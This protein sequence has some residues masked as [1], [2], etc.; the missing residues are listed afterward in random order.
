MNRIW[1]CAPRDDLPLHLETDG[2]DTG[3]GAVFF[4]IVD[5]KRHVIKMCS[6]KWYTEVWHKKQPYHREAKAWMEGMKRT[7]PLAMNNPFPIE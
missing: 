6:K 4:Q 1:T 3:W 7:I 2:S 5:G